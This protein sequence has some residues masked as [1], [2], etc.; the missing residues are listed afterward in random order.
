MREEFPGCVGLE[1]Y[2]VSRGETAFH[3]TLWHGIKVKELIKCSALVNMPDGGKVKQSRKDHAPKAS[4]GITD[5]EIIGFRLEVRA[6]FAQSFSVFESI[7]P[8]S[9]QDSFNNPNQDSGLFHLASQGAVLSGDQRNIVAT[10]GGEVS[11]MVEQHF[12]RAL[13]VEVVRDHQD[14][15]FPHSVLVHKMI[16][17]HDNRHPVEV[18][19]LIVVRILDALVSAEKT[20][21]LLGSPPFSAGLGAAV[22]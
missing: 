15:Q 14:L 1:N 17:I 18:K 3:Q 19:I 12:R 21:M 13:Q 2:S 11:R 22:D 9:W 16:G 7:F 4:Q 20:Q 8:R 6:N 10:A 5:D